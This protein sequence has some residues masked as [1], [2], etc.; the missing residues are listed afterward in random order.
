MDRIDGYNYITVGQNRQFTD[1]PPATVIPS[2]WLN[3]IQEEIMAVITG[4]GLVPSA[5]NLGQLWQA[6]VL[7]A[8]QQ[9]L[10]VGTISMYG[11]VTPPPGWLLCNGATVS[12]TTYASLYGIIGSSFNYGGEGGG[13]F[14]LPDF[15]GVFPKGAGNAGDTTGGISARTAGKDASGN[16][17]AATL[18]A[19]A[20]DKMQ[21]HI[22]TVNKWNVTS[23]NGFSELGASGAAYNTSNPADD[24]TNGTPRTGHTTEPQSLGVYFIIKY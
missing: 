15:R 10:P 17:Y 8:T 11:N 16:Y 20:T 6:I 2:R 3:A 23:G 13:T 5:S 22:H 1:G 7:Q 21:G 9:A 12:Q 18:G 24:G 19:Y 14:R 4:A